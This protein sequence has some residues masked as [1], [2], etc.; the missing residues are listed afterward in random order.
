M[1]ELR[2]VSV[3]NFKTHCLQYLEQASSLK[4]ECIVT[5]RGKPIAKLIPIENQQQPLKFGSMNR[6]GSIRGD[7]VDPI[8]GDWEVCS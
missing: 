3:S 2:T 5:K 1:E 7:V 4:I 8:H 6:T